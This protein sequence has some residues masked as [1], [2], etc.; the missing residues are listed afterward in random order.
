MSN[1]IKI[2]GRRPHQFM[3]TP[4]VE[5]MEQAASLAG[6]RWQLKQVIE[7]MKL[8]HGDEAAKQ[9]ILDVANQVWPND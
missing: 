4:A 8:L 1:I 2:G 5:N 3:K 9:A 6:N 7:R